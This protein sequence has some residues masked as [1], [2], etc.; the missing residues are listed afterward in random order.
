[1]H[2]RTL[3]LLIGVAMLPALLLPG[4]VHGGGHHDTRLI[5]GLLVLQVGVRAGSAG[6][7]VLTEG[8]VRRVVVVGSGIL[9]GGSQCC[10]TCLIDMLTVNPM[11][12]PRGGGAKQARW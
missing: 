2:L 1:M 7:E 6:V 12:K 10:C 3:C 4:L 11:C 9:Q 5:G 8:R